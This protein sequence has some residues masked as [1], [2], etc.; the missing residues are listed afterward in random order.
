VIVH[1][2]P[3]VPDPPPVKAVQKQFIIPPP[4][5]RKPETHK[6]ELPPVPV[7]APK[8]V[9]VA[10]LEAPKIEARP[11]VAPHEVFAASNEA[12]PSKE[13]VK[14][15]KTGGFGDPNGAQPNPNSTKPSELAAVGSFDLSKGSGH[16]AGS[17]SNGKTL[18]AR[19]GFGDGL[20]AAPVAGT[21]HGGV[22]AGGFGDGPGG[23]PASTGGG[24]RGTVQAGGFNTYEAPAKPVSAV[25][26]PAAPA[27]TPVEITYKPKPAYTP[28]AR[29]KK[30]EG[31][32]ELEV[33]FSAAGQ[34]QVIRLIR[35]LGYGLDENARQAASQIRFRPGTRNGVPVD[36]TGTV[37]ITF[38]IS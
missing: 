26:R 16:A 20:G 1:P 5:V 12:A 30:I 22:Q 23:A 29:E 13:P 8:P 33:L 24:Q 21:P 31:D 25:T 34:I 2:P 19:A 28:E 38:Q 10:K 4:P 15:I 27:Q 37:H 11:P 35:G 36:M 7:E 9:E 17:G 14:A 18:V 6:V 3:P 32:V